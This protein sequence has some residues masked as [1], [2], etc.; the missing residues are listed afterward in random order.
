M[1]IISKLIPYD[2][3]KIHSYIKRKLNQIYLYLETSNNLH[4][5]E[6]NIILLSYF[7]KYTSKCIEDSLETI[8]INLLYQI[9]TFIISTFFH[10]TKSL[11]PSKIHLT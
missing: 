10:H 6:K 4:R 2:F 3:A 8:F 1:E 11:I 9:P 5:Q 7:I